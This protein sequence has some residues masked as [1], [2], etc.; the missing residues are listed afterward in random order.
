MPFPYRDNILFNSPSTA[1]LAPIFNTPVR[2]PFRPVCV[3]CCPSHNIQFNKAILSSH[4]IEPRQ[5]DLQLSRRKNDK[6]I[7]VIRQSSQDQVEARCLDGD[8]REW[9]GCC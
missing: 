2:L 7:G 9:M 6:H 3:P 5:V 4:Y 8:L 1:D